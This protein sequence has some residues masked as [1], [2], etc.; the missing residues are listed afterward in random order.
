MMCERC[1]DERC[2]DP[3]SKWCSDILLMRYKAER[4][5]LI[6]INNGWAAECEKLEEERDAFRADALRYRWLRGHMFFTKRE[7]GT[8]AEFPE[9]MIFAVPVSAEKHKQ[10]DAIDAAI[11]AAREKP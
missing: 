1:G 11:D 3:D 7:W 2:N 4:D 10:N 8:Y 6:R 5:T 9:S